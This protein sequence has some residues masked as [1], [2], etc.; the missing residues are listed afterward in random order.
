MSRL[1]SDNE[2]EQE[3]SSP[4]PEDDPLRLLPSIQVLTQLTYHTTIPA[5]GKP[6]KPKDQKLMKTKELP[7]HFAANIDIY[8]KFLNAVRQKHGKG[9]AHYWEVLEKKCGNDHDKSYTYIGPNETFHLTPLMMAAWAHALYESIPGVTVE[10]YPNQDIFNMA[11]HQAALRTGRPLATPI[12]CALQGLTNTQV[13]TPSPSPIPLDLGHLATIVTGLAALTGRVTPNHTM[14]ASE[15]HLTMFHS[16]FPP[17]PT[18]SKLHC[19]LKHAEDNLGVPDALHY[20]ASLGQDKYGPDIL[21]LVPDERLVELGVSCGD[22]IHLKSSSQ[23]WWNSANVK[24]R[25]HADSTETHNDPFISTPISTSGSIPANKK[26]I[27]L[28]GI[29]VRLQEIECHFLLVILL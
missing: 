1:N 2:H 10:K 12:T 25:R 27:T 4:P 28:H 8:V 20:E 3:E 26:L 23:H 14:A 9:K 18:S 13:A 7:F 29:G 24:K 15:T 19:F 22:V 11:N 5:V 16:S 17:L 21:H 6:G